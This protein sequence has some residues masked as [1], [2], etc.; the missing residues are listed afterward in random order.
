MFF[1]SLHRQR[2][3]EQWSQRK[4]DVDVAD[5]NVQG[6]QSSHSHSDEP[7]SLLTCTPSP[8]DGEPLLHKLVIHPRGEAYS[9]LS[10]RLGD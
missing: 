5:G 10:E 6:I 8:E 9:T 3:T 7:G 4:P 2:K 1:C